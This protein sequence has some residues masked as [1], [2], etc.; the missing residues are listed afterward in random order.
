VVSTPA[1]AN[2]ASAMP[3]TVPIRF[4]YDVPARSPVWSPDGRQ[5]VLPDLL[6]IGGD[7]STGDA[8]GASGEAADHQDE[9][10]AV[11]LV[12]ID[13]ESGQV[14]DISGDDNADGIRVKDSAPAWSP[15][16]GWIAGR[17]I[18]LTRPDA[19][20]AYA[21][22]TEPMA[23]MGD[24]FAFAWRPDGGALAYLR[25]DLSEGPQPVPDVSVWYFD[26][27]QGKSIPVADDG[28]LPKWLP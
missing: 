4:D 13:L 28:V 1:P 16:G 2:G 27:A 19:S 6:V 11:R 17:Q 18:W 20:E 7:D 24:H 23:T 21:L 26:F 8:A 12:R 15:G 22:L 9:G 5:L 10:L 3:S 25:G 14:L